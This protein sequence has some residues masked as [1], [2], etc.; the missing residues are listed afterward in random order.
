MILKPAQQAAADHFLANLDL[1]RVLLLQGGAGSGKTTILEAL[2]ASRG[3]V[4]L[5]ASEH[6][7]DSFL[8]VL[9]QAVYTHA[10]VLADDLHLAAPATRR[11]GA[12]RAYLFDA[13]LTAILAD[14]RLL[15]RTLIF[16]VEERAPWPVER[17]AEIR[18]SITAAACVCVGQGSA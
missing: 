15:G 7:E 11:R 16:S 9:E 2:R 18:A 13:A 8:H 4:L 12:A 5:R 14:A 10:I 6:T 17:R 3:G 1:A